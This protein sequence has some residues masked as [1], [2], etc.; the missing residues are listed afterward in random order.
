MALIK[1][2][3]C[4]HTVLSVASTCPNCKHRMTPE[5]VHSGELTTVRQCRSCGELMTGDSTRCP[6]C[7]ESIRRPI[8]VWI[9]VA[10]AVA[11]LIAVGWL[12]LR[13]GA[14]GEREAPPPTPAPEAS[15]LPV[16]SPAHPTLR[17]SVEPAP[18]EIAVALPPRALR[19]ANDWTN[20]RAD[21]G[22]EYEVVQILRPGDSVEVSDRRLG[23]WAVYLDDR[24]IGYV[25]NNLLDTD[26]P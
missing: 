2:P 5:V 8:L 20:V 22:L 10:V 11:A 19:W 13:D 17:D 25:V 16:Q 3:E 15:R 26:P 6:H 4:G 7:G 1:C 14:E 24:L 21:R 18:A 9:A 12:V 23:W